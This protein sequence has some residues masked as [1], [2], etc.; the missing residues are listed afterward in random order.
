MSDFKAKMHQFAFRWGAYGALQ[1]SL[2][3]FNWPTSR[4]NE[5]KV[6]GKER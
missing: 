1:S 6:Q 4:G 5:G 2:A 3:V